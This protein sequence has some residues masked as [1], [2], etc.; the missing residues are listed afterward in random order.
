M[1]QGTKLGPQKN[2]KIWITD[3]L[4]SAIWLIDYC[5][6]FKWHLNISCFCLLFRCLKTQRLFAILITIQVADTCVPDLTKRPFNAWTHIPDL[7]T[8]QVHTLDPHYWHLLNTQSCKK[9]G[10]LFMRGYENHIKQKI[11]DL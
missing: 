2:E 1:Q 4:L 10:W 3:N 5:L 6:L 9:L 8:R 11:T 7:N